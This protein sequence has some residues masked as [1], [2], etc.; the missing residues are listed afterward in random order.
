MA[1]LSP[2]GLSGEGGGGGEGVGRT[3]PI[4][5]GFLEGSERPEAG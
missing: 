3:R 2:S 1:G 5:G 4:S